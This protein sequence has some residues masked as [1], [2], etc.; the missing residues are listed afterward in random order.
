[1]SELDV[2]IQALIARR[3][4]QG[5]DATSIRNELMEVHLMDETIADTHIA[6]YLSDTAIQQAT[7]PNPERTKR[8][9]VTGLTDMAIGAGC[10][11]VAIGVFFFDLSD[12]RPTGMVI[13]WGGLVIFGMYRFIEGL[14]SFVRGR[15]PSD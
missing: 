15:Y 11:A 1:M 10:C 7:A 9:R 6:R 4:T 12:Q 14:W 5:E 13:V 3:I 2:T 8:I